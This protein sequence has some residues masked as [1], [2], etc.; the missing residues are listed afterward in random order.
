VCPTTAI[1]CASPA[2]GDAE[3]GAAAAGAA[4]GWTA[5][6]GAARRIAAR[7]APLA[8]LRFCALARFALALFVALAPAFPP[9]PLT[10][11]VG[12]AP[13]TTSIAATASAT[14]VNFRI[15]PPLVVAERFFPMPR[16]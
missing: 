14:I 4:V 15:N 9:P 5:V 10:G 12:A 13:V 1:S 8:R 16:A 2:R 3:A 6:A 7:F 11:M